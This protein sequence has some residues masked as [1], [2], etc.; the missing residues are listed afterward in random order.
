MELNKQYVVCPGKLRGVLVNI[1]V[2]VGLAEGDAA[3]V[4]ANLVDANLC[5]VDT[6]GIMRLASY[7]DRFENG[8]FSKETRSG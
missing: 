6:H 8:T 2:K 3:I 5:G 7:I 4:A 1:F